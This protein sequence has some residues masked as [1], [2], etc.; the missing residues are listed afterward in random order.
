[1]EKLQDSL[2][3]KKGDMVESNGVK[4]RV[5]DADKKI[6]EA[7]RPVDKKAVS[8]TIASTVKVKDQTCTVASIA[9]NAFTKM[10]KLNKVIVGKKCNQDRQ[11]SFLCR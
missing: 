5:T 3:L 4:Y 7:Y 11:E 6:V 9:D 10:K 2:K 1:M 8:I